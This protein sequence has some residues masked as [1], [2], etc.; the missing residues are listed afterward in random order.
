[1]STSPRQQDPAN[2]GRREGPLNGHGRESSIDLSWSGSQTGRSLPS[3]IPLTK[4]FKI[5][6]RPPKHSAAISRTNSWAIAHPPCIR[7]RSVYATQAVVKRPPFDVPRLLVRPPGGSRLH[8][9]P[10]SAY[11]AFDGGTFLSDSHTVSCNPRMA[12]DP[13]AD[14]S[15]RSAGVIG[16]SSRPR[17]S[18]ARY[19][20][21]LH[22]AV[23]RENPF[24]VI[25]L[26]LEHTGEEAVCLEPSGSAVEREGIRPG[27][28]SGGPRASR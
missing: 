15:F 4:Q 12:G 20:Q 16:V 19:P 3:K 14:S 28:K 21:A 8:A 26:V 7:R 17:E 1:M 2:F 23:E 18:T 22:G 24:G 13:R 5:R 6:A 27:S 25:D 10:G 9:R 11:A